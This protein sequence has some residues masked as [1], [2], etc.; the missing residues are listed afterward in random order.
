MLITSGWRLGAVLPIFTQTQV[1]NEPM[2]FSASYDYAREH[3][4]PL[5]QAF[6]DTIEPAYHDGIIDTRVHMLMPGWYPCIPGWHHDDVPRTRKDGQ[7]DYDNPLYPQHVM[8]LIGADIS[9]TE[10]ALGTHNW[11]PIGKVLYASAAEDVEEAI[12][13]KRG[14]FDPPYQFYKVKWPEPTLRRVTAPM[15]QLVYF[16]CRTWHRGMA[17][18]GNG[19]RWFGRVGINTGKPFANEIRRQ[20]N[21]YMK[22]VDAG[23]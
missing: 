12:A 22:D 8:G 20:V 6:L 10:F 15:H 5:T 21:V 9:R 17:A 2:F 16:D 4:G 1:K 23:W 7:P 19:W 11:K 13:P 14:Y 3:G 18:T